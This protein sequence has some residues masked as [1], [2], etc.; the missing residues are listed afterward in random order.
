MEIRFE[1]DR[2]CIETEVRRTYERLLKQYFK[3]EED[4]N[5]R[6][7]LEAQIEGLK[8]FL[9]LIDVK[10]L[11]SSYPELDKGGE[12]DVILKVKSADQEMVLIFNGKEITPPR[13]S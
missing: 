4:K 9:E 11:R 13:K 5:S 2:F 8:A 1:T 6:Q 12:A 3:P 7:K 10:A